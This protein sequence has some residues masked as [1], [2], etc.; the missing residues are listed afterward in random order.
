MSLLSVPK[1]SPVT[2]T[3]GWAEGVAAPAQEWTETLAPPG[4]LEGP[5]LSPGEQTPDDKSD[6]A[7][8]RG[9]GTGAQSQVVSGGPVPELSS[10]WMPRLLAPP[11]PLEFKV[12]QQG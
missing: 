3:S 2:G 11:P 10:C 9:K 12:G 4:L 7:E 5:R 8:Q 1:E 6:G